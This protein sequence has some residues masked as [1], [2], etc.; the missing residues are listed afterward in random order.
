[1]PIP[2]FA[3]AEVG[4]VAKFFLS[5]DSKSRAEASKSIKSACSKYGSKCELKTIDI[6]VRTDEVNYTKSQILEAT[7]T[8]KE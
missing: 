1:M 7:L 2:A 6:L 4:T 8:N 5:L 3:K